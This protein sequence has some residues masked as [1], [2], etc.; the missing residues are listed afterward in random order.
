MCVYVCAKPARVGSPR[1]TRLL[2][3]C[4]SSSAGSKLT[5]YNTPHTP[6]VSAYTQHSRS[7]N[8]GLC[9]ADM[10]QCVCVCRKKVLQ[11]NKT[12]HDRA[13]ADIGGQTGRGMVSCYVEMTGFQPIDCLDSDSSRRHSQVTIK[14]TDEGIVTSCRYD[15]PL[16]EYTVSLF[17]CT[18]MTVKHY[19]LTV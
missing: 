17:N 13:T 1:V 6:A 14:R 19:F 9:C 8:Q 11:Q 15:R 5:E 4:D 2:S 18:Y 10:G 7:P 12:E 3:A 16:R